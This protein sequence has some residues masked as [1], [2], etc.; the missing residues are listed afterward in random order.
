MIK[1][2]DC[3]GLACP[4]PALKTKKAL[5]TIESGQIL[6]IVDN[7]AAKENITRL[8]NF[9]GC[10]INLEKKGADFYLTITKTKKR[11]R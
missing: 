5:D 8:A 7:N 3:R 4:I 9:M 6:T 10:D 1:E 11:G 2:I